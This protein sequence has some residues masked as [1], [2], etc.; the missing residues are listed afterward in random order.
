MTSFNNGSKSLKSLSLIT[1]SLRAYVRSFISMTVSS[2][3]LITYFSDLMHWREL[4]IMALRSFGLTFTVKS[5]DWIMGWSKFSFTLV[6]PQPTHGTSRALM[7]YCSLLLRWALQS[8]LR[9]IRLFL[10]SRYLIP[11]M[12]W[13]DFLSKNLAPS[14][15]ITPSVR[16]SPKSMSHV[17]MTYGCSASSSLEPSRWVP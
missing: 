14:T 10:R 7:K 8:S 4:P 5:L 13:R 15:A 16:S 2:I 1:S 9:L 3:P 11:F 17:L 12:L 6:F